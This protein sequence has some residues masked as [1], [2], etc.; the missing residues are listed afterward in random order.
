MKVKLILEITD[1]QGDCPFYNVSFEDALLM[2]H[3]SHPDGKMYIDNIN[4][5]PFK[6]PLRKFEVKE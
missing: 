5:I 1:C 6:C 2:H 4:Q 3:C